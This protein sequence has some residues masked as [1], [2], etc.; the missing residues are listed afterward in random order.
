M[1]HPDV[2]LEGILISSQKIHT[3]R[4]RR[5]R[6]KHWR[7]EHVN[8]GVTTKASP[9]CRKRWPSLLFLNV[10]KI[11]DLHL[12]CDHKLSR[13]FWN[14]LIR[15]DRKRC[16]TFG[17]S[18]RRL[19]RCH[20]YYTDKPRPVHH[21]QGSQKATLWFVLLPKLLQQCLYNL[22]CILTENHIN[23]PNNVISC[24]KISWFWIFEIKNG[25][26]TSRC[27]IL[28]TCIQLLFIKRLCAKYAN[29]K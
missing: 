9:H 10:A 19:W 26:W 8:E 22:E 6:I 15:A 20:S 12:N 24:F 13:L 3:D 1:S 17:W 5:P 25:Q 18:S 2:E 11:L 29:V 28:V 27:I 4:W 21:V 23:V 7:R 16:C 14:L